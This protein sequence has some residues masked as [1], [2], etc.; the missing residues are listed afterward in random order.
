MNDGANG[1]FMKCQNGD[2][3]WILRNFYCLTLFFFFPSALILSY[4]QDTSQ[5]IYLTTPSSYQIAEITFNLPCDNKLW[6]AQSASDWWG[7]LHQESL[8]G[9]AQERLICPTLP[10]LLHLVFEPRAITKIIPISYFAH[11]TVIHGIIS[12]LFT[13]CTNS[14][15]SPQTGANGDNM[16][17]ELYSIQFALHNWLQLWMRRP[18]VNI[19]EESE[20]PFMQNRKQS[21]LECVSEFHISL[22]S[23]SV[24]LAW[25]SSSDGIPGELAPFQWSTVR[26]HCFENGD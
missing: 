10:E 26:D 2:W 6:H 5:C 19:R 21:A 12:R 20:P 9:N 15:L 4:L 24:L 18:E 16:D 13:V 22:N 14:R 8:Y 17:Q 7:E 3:A 11:W 23:S 25:T 1:L